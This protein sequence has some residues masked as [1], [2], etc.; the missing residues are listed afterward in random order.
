MQKKS[1]DQTIKEAIDL[2]LETYN[3]KERYLETSVAARWEE[4]SGKAIA[5]RT[6]DV[7]IKQKKLYLQL[8]SPILKQE[9]LLSKKKLISLV[10]EKLGGEVIKDIVLT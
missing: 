3:L 4:I 7:Y 9:I 5:N 1:N 10:N 2:L 8:S 6:L